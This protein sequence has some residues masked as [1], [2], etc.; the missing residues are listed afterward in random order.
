MK[1]MDTH[2][3]FVG[4]IVRKEDLEIVEAVHEFVEKE[5]M[6]SRLDLEGGWHR[7]EK[8]ARATFE[9]L[10]KGLVDLGIQRAFLP[11]EIGGLGIASSVTECMVWEE[12][13][14]GDCGLAVHLA[15]LPWVMGPALIARRKDLLEIFGRKICDDK[16]HTA[17]MAITEPEGGANIEDP[18]L[19]GRTI[20][21]RAELKHDVWV[22]N[23]EKIWPSG[24][25]V[26]DIAYCTVCS[27]DPSKGDE[28][29]ALIYVPPDASGLSFGKPI[30]KMG[31]CW[32]DI[33]AE[34]FYENV[35][36]SKEYRVAGPGKD[37]KI[38]HDIISAGRLGTAAMAVG[39]AQAA[40]EM[41]LSWTKERKIAGKPVREHSLFASIIGEMAMKIE[42]ARAYYM[43]VAWMHDHHE[44]YGRGGEPLMLARTSAAKAFAC[45][46]AV[47]VTN[48]AMELMGSYGYAFDHH[49][50]KYLRDCKILQL[51]LGGP[52]RAILDMALGYYPFKWNQ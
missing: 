23:G 25:G 42:A 46:T 20:N 35:R 15:I 28:G 40:L 14:R 2:R 37:A 30:E 22:I 5:V 13:A 3:K 44:I 27:T 38:L 18:T 32:T 8:L 21:T 9:K 47:W 33:N 52:Q 41:V 49:L 43:Q 45:D 11:E 7:D 34:I 1:M 4:A 39:V 12:I 29:I 16:P 51:W 17:C 6:P 24:A 26:A 48:K 19:H 31:M 50:E 10:H 36:V